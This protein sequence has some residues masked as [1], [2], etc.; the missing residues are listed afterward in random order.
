M[1]TA[2]VMHTAI[3]IQC[4]I[5]HECLSWQ[6][7][8]ADRA[9]T[10]LLALA[11]HPDA[12]L[13]ACTEGFAA[14]LGGRGERAEVLKSATDL[15]LERF[16]GDAAVPVQLAALIFGQDQVAL[17]PGLPAD[18]ALCQCCWPCDNAPHPC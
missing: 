7:G 10:E 18:A 16:S 8:D 12:S 2:L 1:S 17:R 11:A 9:G 15:L 5:K 14:L 6:L 4:C 13:G 3:S